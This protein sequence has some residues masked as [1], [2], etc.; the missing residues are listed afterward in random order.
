MR[1][2]TDKTEAVM[3]GLVILITTCIALVFGTM[4]RAY[5]LS[6]L[7]AW[8]IVSTFHLVQIGIAQAIG[9]SCVVSL[10]TYQ[11]H[12]E[13]ED[14]RGTGEIIGSVLAM[15]FF[16]PAFVLLFGWIAKGWL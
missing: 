1:T 11:H 14:E 9:I 4:W 3:A 13:P 2:N 6:R 16:T 12:R 7:W 10:L 5:V 15:A 8:F